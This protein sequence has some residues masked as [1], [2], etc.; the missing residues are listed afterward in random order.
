MTSDIGYSTLLQMET[1]GAGK[2]QEYADNLVALSERAANLTRG[3]LTFSRKQVM[4]PRMVDLNDL[5]TTITRLVGRLI[6]ENIT[7]ET[8]LAPSPLTIMADSG[9]I[10]QVL[11]NL[12]TNARD[13]MP[14]GGRLLIETEL[15]YLEPDDQRL[16]VDAHPGPYAQLSVSDTGSGMD[17]GTRA[18]IFE[19]FFTTKETG[20]GTGLGLS[21]I[22]GIISQHRG[23]ISVSSQPGCGTVVKVYF[24]SVEP[25]DQVR[26][27]NP[28]PAAGGS[29]TILI[30]EDDPASRTIIKQILR[31]FGYRV[32]EATDGEEAV[33]IFRESRGPIPLVILDM[34]MP[35]KN[36]QEAFA[37]IMEM[38]P[39]VRALFIS[40]YAVD[41]SARGEVLPDGT[42]FLP[43]PVAPGELLRSI[44]L[45]L[46]GQVAVD[47]D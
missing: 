45:L 4:T 14:R 32:L 21:I 29:E 35:R 23:T 17:E 3:L 44:R 10:E 22:Y 47:R 8:R 12:A 46:D 30:A 9:Q 15:V 33:A 31:K 5:V 37:T 43:K 11:M 42:L 26:S 18:R 1:A 40:G 13:A 24:P 27:E 16:A 20:K 2:I 38:N 41:P 6:G 28:A 34:V 36:G 19:P 39:G 7:V 25:V